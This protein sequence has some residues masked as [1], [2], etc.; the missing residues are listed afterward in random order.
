MAVP[1]PSLKPTPYGV[2]G[3]QY[4]PIAS[5]TL[6]PPST[7]IGHLGVTE[8]SFSFASSGQPSP[9]DY[10]TVNLLEYSNPT[11]SL[12]YG[13]RDTFPPST[14]I[15]RGH[16]MALPN[17]DYG[18]NIDEIDSVYFEHVFLTDWFSSSIWAPISYIYSFEDQDN[19]SP[20]P[21]NNPTPT[22]TWNVTGTHNGWINGV[23]A[24]NGSTFV[25][26]LTT[27][28]WNIGVG[29]EFSLANGTGTPSNATG[30]SG[31]V[32]ADGFTPG[33]SSQG[34]QRFL[35]TESSSPNASVNIVWLA[36]TPGVNISASMEDPT[37]N[38]AR[39]RFKVHAYGSA[40]G[41]LKVYVDTFGQSSSTQATLLAEYA[42]DSW[43][44]QS[45]TD[46]YEEAIISLP[47]N[48]TQTDDEYYFFITHQLSSNTFT[49]DLAIDRVVFEEEVITPN[50]T[51]DF[52]QEVAS[53]N[54][55]TLIQDGNPP[56]QFDWDCSPTGSANVT[57][58]LDTADGAYIKAT[59]LLI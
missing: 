33:G 59:Y 50:Y 49:G 22:N 29:G 14:V 32:G 18:S 43:N 27:K 31:G 53:G 28:G 19:V 17:G 7:G 16:I 37:N 30:P 25:N 51:S 58:T 44:Q 40:T 36:R 45:G 10:L 38:S 39:L 48:I 35:Y 42:A 5:S 47:T 46:P 21:P 1:S 34:A 55:G 57:F 52:Y 8:K 9:Y 13:Q 23:Q 12:S 41:E 3:I 26:G 24:A 54:N 4:Y 20:T 6:S 15:V 2:K 11:Q 56:V